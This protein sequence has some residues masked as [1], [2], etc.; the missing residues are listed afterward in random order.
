[1]EKM[2]EQEQLLAEREEA[3]VNLGEIRKE[4]ELF[5]RRLN[6]LEKLEN[7]ITDRSL[8]KQGDC[9]NQLKQIAQHQGEFKALAGRVRRGDRER[10][11]D[12]Q[13]QLMELG[14][15]KKVI[16]SVAR[17]AERSGKS[18]CQ[19]IELAKEERGRL[20]QR[21]EDLLGM[22]EMAGQAELTRREVETTCE[23]ICSVKSLLE[24]EEKAIRERVL[25]LM[26]EIPSL[27][28]RWL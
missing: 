24:G 6:M 3:Q 21:V 22:V 23:R 28:R 26:F 16:Q 13:K 25:D 14:K 7:L 5:I 18:L 10:R 15:H 4:L 1:M 20:C 27:S 17:Q 2:I 19:Q 11:R 12:I 8:E 9:L